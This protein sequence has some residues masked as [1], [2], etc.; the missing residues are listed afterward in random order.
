MLSDVEGNERE[1][2]NKQWQIVVMGRRNVRVSVG[3]RRTKIKELNEEQR[4]REEHNEEE[5]ETSKKR[6]KGRKKRKMMK[7]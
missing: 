3:V 7:K 2:N 1:M 6:V 4:K 5:V